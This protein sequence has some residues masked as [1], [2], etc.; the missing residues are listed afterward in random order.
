MS[1]D[2]LRSLKSQND[3]KLTILDLH[4]EDYKLQ[5]KQLIEYTG[6]DEDSIEGYKEMENTD[7]AVQSLEDYLQALVLGLGTSN[8]VF[9]QISIGLFLNPICRKKEALQAVIASNQG[10]DFFPYIRKGMDKN[11]MIFTPPEKANISLDGIEPS[12]L[13]YYAEMTIARQVQEKAKENIKLDVTT[14]VNL[15]LFIEKIQESGYEIV[16]RCGNTIWPINSAET[17]INALE[18]LVSIEN[19]ATIEV[20]ADFGKKEKEAKESQAKLARRGHIKP[21]CW[22]QQG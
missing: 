3:G 17:Y 16:L 11:Y 14:V 18:R 7:A 2:S 13:E 19:N 4:L 22:Y 6:P 5:G 9:D 8:T 15:P 21:P 1:L 12:T 20:V 10:K